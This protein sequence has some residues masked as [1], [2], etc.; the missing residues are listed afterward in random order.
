MAPVVAEIRWKRSLPGRESGG[1][2][3]FER[4]DFSS[5]KQNERRGGRANGR[6]G[7]CGG[8][9]SGEGAKR[10]GGVGS[11]RALERPVMLG[12]G[13]DSFDGAD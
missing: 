2:G 7:T 8:R 5:G 12:T 11:Q 10:Y 6:P 9:R 3:R 13:A 4:Q 1:N